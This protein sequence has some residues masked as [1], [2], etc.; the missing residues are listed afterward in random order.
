MLTD[1]L[2]RAAKCLKIYILCNL[3]KYQCLVALQNKLKQQKHRK[4]KSGYTSYDVEI[5]NYGYIAGSHVLI[6]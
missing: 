5:I 3:V 1:L 4:I 6:Q 2:F